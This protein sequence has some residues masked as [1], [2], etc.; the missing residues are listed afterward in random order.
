MESIKFFLNNSKK[1]LKKF[2]KF[3]KLRFLLFQLPYLKIALVFQLF[4]P[5]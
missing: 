5:L 4:Q 2:F 3:Q 1:Q